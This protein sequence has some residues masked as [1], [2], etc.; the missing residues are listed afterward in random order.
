MN[1]L[2]ASQ[3]EVCSAE[4]VVFCPVASVQCS[5][6]CGQVWTSVQCAVSRLELVQPV[7]YQK[8]SVQC[9]TLHCCAVQCSAGSASCDI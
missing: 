1:G 6:K 9:S 5:G 8:C 2:A 4:S 3:R 7:A